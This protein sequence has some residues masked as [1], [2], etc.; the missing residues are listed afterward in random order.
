V[1]TEGKKAA[2]VLEYDNQ[3]KPVVAKPVAVNQ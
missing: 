1:P 2:K 3:T